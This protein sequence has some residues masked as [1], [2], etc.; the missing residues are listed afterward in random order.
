M[1]FLKLVYGKNLK[2]TFFIILLVPSILL[3]AQKIL[4]QNPFRVENEVS[5]DETPYGVFP[6]GQM[7]VVVMRTGMAAFY[8]ENLTLRWNVGFSL[9]KDYSNA[10][11][12]FLNDSLHFIFRGKDKFVYLRISLSDGNGTAKYMNLTLTD[13]ENINR[14]KISENKAMFLVSNKD[15]YRFLMYSYDRDTFV[16]KEIPLRGGYNCSSVVFDTLYGKVYAL[17]NSSSYREDAL[18]LAVSDTLLTE[19]LLNEVRVN[20]SDIRLLNGSIAMLGGDEI[21]IAGSWNF[22]KNKQDV[23][24]YDK[25]TSSAGIY[26]V[27]CR[28]GTVDSAA[29]VLKTYSQFSQSNNRE[30]LAQ[31]RVVPLQGA[32]N[33]SGGFAVLSEV[34]ERKFFTTTETYYDAY[35]RIIP[36]TRTMYEG[37]SFTNVFCGLF[38]ADGQRSLKNDGLYVF[39]VSSDNVYSALFDYSAF[40][41]DSF[42][43]ILYAFPSEGRVYYRALPAAQDTAYMV[44]LQ[45]VSGGRL[46]P[47]YSGDRVQ[48]NWNNRVINWYGGCFLACGY[49]Q[50]LNHKA[51]R[52]VRNVFY[53]NKLLMGWR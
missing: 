8:D 15:K 13:N 25:G 2:Y 24:Y 33:N 3:H 1:P 41:Q 48:K 27:V 17:F 29:T 5:G 23:S 12:E 37:V 30:Y 4:P 53:L 44:Y 7:G 45:D 21:A 31:T 43:N 36:Y 19:V 22:N 52:S 50:I 35:G 9:G 47:L 38:S 28:N 6:L 51:P 14:V 32:G 10:G 40:A 11:Y 16:A 39:D 49:Q 46:T 20:R 18:L 26:A 34:Y 42:G